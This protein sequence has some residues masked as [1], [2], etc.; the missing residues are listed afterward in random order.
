MNN[1]FNRAPLRRKSCEMKQSSRCFRPLQTLAASWLV[2]CATSCGVQ[3]SVR[4]QLQVHSPPGREGPN[5]EIQAQ[6][7][8]PQTG[9]R[10]KWFSVSGQCDPQESDAPFTVFHFAEGVSRDRVSVEIWRNNQR[11]AS[12]EV[13]VKITEQARLTSARSPEIQVE[14]T[15]IP[16]EEPDLPVH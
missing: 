14:I 12:G 16:P 15:T 6:V 3:D 2:L 9:L 7:T 10:Y 13:D 11:L 5:L 8:G 4:V 1:I